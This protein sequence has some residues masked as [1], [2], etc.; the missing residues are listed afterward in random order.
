MSSLPIIVLGTGGHARVVVDA[1]ECA[2]LA[3]EGAVAPT[4]VADVLGVPYLGSDELLVARGAGAVRLANGVGSVD[5]DGRRAALFERY[6]ELGFQF[7]QVLHP[8][9]IIARATRVGHGAQV[10]AGAVVQTG[11]TLDRNVIVN[12]RASVDHDC[13]IGA[14]VHVAPGA[15]LAGGVVVAAGAHIGAGA[16]VLQGRTVGA[17]AVVAAGAVV[18]RNVPDGAVVVG[19]PARERSR[20]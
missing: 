4:A 5:A 20:G 10:F 8:S 9:A 13:V 17:G 18:D 3:I 6:I 14:H 16:V 11:T 1:L 2:G 7:V 15:T 19:V 12:T